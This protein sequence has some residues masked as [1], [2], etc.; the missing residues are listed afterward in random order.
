MRDE[1]ISMLKPTLIDIIKDYGKH[2]HGV[3]AISYIKLFAEL[4]Q[5]VGVIFR[6]IFVSKFITHDDS[7]DMYFASTDSGSRYYVA[8]N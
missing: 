4:E 5:R 8:L 6:S 7:F 3:I 2:Q 1:I